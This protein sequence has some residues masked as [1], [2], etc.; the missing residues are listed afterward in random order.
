[1]KDKPLLK[2]VVITL[3]VFLLMQAVL[4]YGLA[5]VG[6]SSQTEQTDA[7]QKAVMRAVFTCYAIEGRYPPSTSYLKD[8][9]GLIYDENKYIVTINTFSENLLPDIAILPE[10][11]A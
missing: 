5:Q 2:G 11:G 1:M 8:H 3:L 7:L 4:A 6:K 10:G 9:Y